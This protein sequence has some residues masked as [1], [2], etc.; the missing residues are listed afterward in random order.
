[1]GAAQSTPLEC[2]GACLGQSGGNSQLEER[3]AILE[4]ENL[5]LRRLLK[6]QEERSSKANETSGGRAPALLRYGS[7]QFSGRT[8][9]DSTLTAAAA[10]VSAAEATATYQR[11][12][13]RVEVDNETD[14]RATLVTVRAPGRVRLFGDMC[15][16]VAGLGLT[17][18]YAQID[19]PDGGDGSLHGGSNQ[20]K[21]AVL[22]FSLL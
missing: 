11:S 17:S 1:M 6:E 10:V 18:L 3:C 14:E 16:A 15:G 13:V 22:K 12:L 20:Q 19:G 8:D 5:R 9:D 21:V 4:A 2:A 7:A